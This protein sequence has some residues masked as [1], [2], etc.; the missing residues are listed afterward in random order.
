MNELKE[1][2]LNYLADLEDREMELFNKHLFLQ[3]H[4]FLEEAK[5]YYRSANLLANER[6]EICNRVFG[7]HVLSAKTERNKFDA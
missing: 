6:A 3:R 5:P 2:L 4:N 7:V 1:N